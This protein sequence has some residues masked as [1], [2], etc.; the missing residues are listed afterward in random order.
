MGWQ[1]IRGHERVVEGFAHVVKT[2]RL[3][4]AYLFAGLPGI[5]KKLFA[6][7]LAKTLL[8]EERSEVFAACDQCAS[9]TLIDAG[10]HP[11]FFCIGLPVD[12]NELPIERM[13]DLCSSFSL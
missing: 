10:T 5:G 8:C 7:E 3:A 2:G 4:H 11:D 6:V 9:C 12:K 1:R 13:Q